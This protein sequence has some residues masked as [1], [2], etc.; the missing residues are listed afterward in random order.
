MILDMPTCGGCRTC[1]MA[2]SFKHRGEFIPA[3]S[4]IKILDKKDGIG[5]LVFLAQGPQ[6]PEIP[7]DGCGELAV[8]LCMQYCR[9]SEDLREVLDAFMGRSEAGDR[10]NLAVM[11]AAGKEI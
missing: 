2:C 4:S 1:E 10:E 7:C 3:I 11:Q 8:P 6:G 5:F 9:K